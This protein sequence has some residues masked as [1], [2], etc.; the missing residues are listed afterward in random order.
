MKLKSL[1][2]YLSRDSRIDRLHLKYDRLRQKI[3]QVEGIITEKS[4]FRNPE[5]ILAWMFFCKHEEKDLYLKLEYL[6][7]K[8]DK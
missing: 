4:T 5:D 8:A 7:K 3:G 6:H 2:F 1:F